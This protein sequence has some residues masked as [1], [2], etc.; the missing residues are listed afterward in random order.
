MTF[1]LLVSYREA[2]SSAIDSI[3]IHCHLL[4]RTDGVEIGT[5]WQTQ[6][7]ACGTIINNYC[8]GTLSWETTGGLALFS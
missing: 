5:C 4:L 8:V 2:G 3:L 1:R 6:A 7:L